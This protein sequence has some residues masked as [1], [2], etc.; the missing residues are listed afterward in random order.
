M[1]P[2]HPTF[3]TQLVPQ[4]GR[5]SPELRA[6]ATVCPRCPCVSA[7]FSTLFRTRPGT[8]CSLIGLA[9]HLPGTLAVG[10]RPLARHVPAHFLAD[11]PFVG[12][13]NSSCAHLDFFIFIIALRHLSQPLNS[14]DAAIIVSWECKHIVQHLSEATRRP[15]RW[16]RVIPSPGTL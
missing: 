5:S 13:T 4:C 10:K 11:Y 9:A 16:R 8:V 7:S 14:L 3:H 15:I 12:L 1:T 6:L 2:D